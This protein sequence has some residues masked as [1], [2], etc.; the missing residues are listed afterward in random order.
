METDIS[1]FPQPGAHVAIER[2]KG[3]LVHGQTEQEIPFEVANATLHLALGLR[4][5]GLTGTRTEAIAVGEV[6]E[7]RVP[8]HAAVGAVVIDGDLEIV[9][10]QLRGNATEVAKGM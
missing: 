5:I 2:L 1:R 9:V 6:A 3:Q 8:E 4:S 7:A 10:E